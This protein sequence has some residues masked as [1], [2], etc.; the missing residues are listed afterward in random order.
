M[1]RYLSKDEISDILSFIKPQKGIPIDTANSVVK[2]NKQDLTDQL[3]SQMV[4][5]DII[6]ELKKNRILLHDVFNS[7]R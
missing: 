4:Y 1:K 2:K 6:P 3:L 7:G 5:P